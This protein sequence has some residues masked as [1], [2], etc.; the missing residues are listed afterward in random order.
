ML[1]VRN[2]A[3]EDSTLP[4]LLDVMAGEVKSERVGNA[5]VMRRL[6]DVVI[7]RVVRS[8]VE[9]RKGDTTGWL[10]AIRDRKIGR[11]LA[12]MHREPGKSWP[13]EALAKVA[14]TS[15]SLFS[16]RFTAVVGA[17][18]AR[19][20]PDGAC[21]SRDVGRTKI[22]SLWPKSPRASVM[23][24]RLLSAALSNDIRT[25]LRVHFEQLT[26]RCLRLPFLPNRDLAAT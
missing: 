11:A 12:A 14:T 21:I 22:G 16:E 6:A 24:Q 3:T 20:L 15:R 17:S 23:N 10:G 4:T 8:W 19:Y 7:A 13:V 1:L 9:S 25:N 2:G 5:T 18:P 26:G